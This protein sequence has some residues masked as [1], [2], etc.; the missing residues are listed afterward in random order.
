MLNQVLRLMLKQKKREADNTFSTSRFFLLMFL[1]SVTHLFTAT[2]LSFYTYLPQRS[3]QTSIQ[4]Q[5]V[6][7]S[8][9]TVQATSDGTSDITLD[10]Q[11][12]A[13]NA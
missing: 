13:Q 4:P 11:P 2:T 1:F 3:Y 5:F 7:D 12:D 10:S 6:Y 9:T 8:S